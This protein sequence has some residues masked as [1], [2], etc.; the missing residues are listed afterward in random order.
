MEVLTPE[1]RRKNMSAIRGK[2]TDPERNVRACL[3][4]LRFRFRLHSRSLPGRPDI[5]LFPRSLSG[6]NTPPLTSI[7]WT[8][9][10]SFP[11]LEERVLFTAHPEFGFILLQ[12]GNFPGVALGL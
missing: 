2:D 8:G 1:Q 10:V 3:H 6:T 11:P 7:P 9:W 5:V 4:R 12:T